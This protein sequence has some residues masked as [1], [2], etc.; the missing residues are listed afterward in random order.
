M[1]AEQQ[2]P[3]TTSTIICRT[4]FEASALQIR[5]RPVLIGDMNSP[6]LLTLA[7]VSVNVTQRARRDVDHLSSGVAL[8]R[9]VGDVTFLSTIRSADM[10]PMGRPP[11]APPPCSTKTG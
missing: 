6:L 10:L 2:F 7:A 4:F 1:L 9:K 5:L 3:W 11:G 8:L